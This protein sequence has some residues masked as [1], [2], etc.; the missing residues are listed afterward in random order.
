MGAM[1]VF[2]RQYDVTTFI[3]DEVF[4]VWRNQEELAF[5]KSPYAT[6]FGQIILPAFPP[7]YVNLSDSR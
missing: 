6:L 5:T 7:L 4:I 1:S 3:T 2:W